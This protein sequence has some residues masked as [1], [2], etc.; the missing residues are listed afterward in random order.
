VGFGLR[1]C[2]PVRVRV[3]RARLQHD[4]IP[5]R[6]SVRRRTAALGVLRSR[7]PPQL[8]PGSR[9]IPSCNSVIVSDLRMIVPCCARHTRTGWYAGDE[10]A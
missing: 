10:L 2:G 1:G 9:S 3:Y 7:R 8:M 6:H 5:S 4:V